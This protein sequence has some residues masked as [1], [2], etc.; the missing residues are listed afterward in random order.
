MTKLSNLTKVTTVG[1]DALFYIVDPARS[2]G[3]R[4]V[5]MDKDDVKTLVGGSGSNTIAPETDLKPINPLDIATYDGANNLTHISIEHV[6]GGWNGYKYWNAFTP[7]PDS[8][9]ENPSVQCSNN[10]KN[11]V[12]PTGLV[13][14]IK[15]QQDAIDEGY[16]FWSDT[17]IT[18]LP[19]NRML[20]LFRAGGNGEGVYKM[21]STDGVNWTNFTKIYSTAPGS[22]ARCLSPTIVILPNGNWRMFFINAIDGVAGNE[23]RYIDSSDEGANWSAVQICSTP[24]DVDRFWHMDII[25]V[26]GVY[27]G[28][29]NKEVQSQNGSEKYPG[30]LFHLKSDNADNWYWGK[31]NI[32]KS[33]TDVDANGYYR[34]SFI[35]KIGD[36]VTFDLWLNSISAGSNQ[37]TDSNW[38]VSY[39][40]N[41]DLNTKTV[42]NALDSSFTL[43]D[44]KKLSHNNK[45]LPI[46][47][48]TT[49]IT[50][51]TDLN[52][53]RDFVCSGYLFGTG[54]IEFIAGA[55]TTIV[56]PKGTSI[57]DVQFGR[58]DIV[59]RN[60]VFYIYIDD[61]DSSGSGGGD[62]GGGNTIPTLTG[63][64]IQTL[65]APFK[66]D[67]ATIDYYCKIIK[68]D[69]TGSTY[70]VFFDDNN[71]ISLSSKVSVTTTPNTET[72]GD[73]VGVDTWNATA[74]YDQI[75]GNELIE[76]QSGVAT[77]VQ[78]G[79]VN[80]ENNRPALKMNGIGSFEGSPDATINSNVAHSIYTLA[81]AAPTSSVGVM[82]SS[83]DTST[84]RLQIYIDKRTAKLI[85]LV[86]DLSDTTYS[87]TYLTT[88]AIDDQRRLVFTNNPQDNFKSYWNKVLQDTTTYGQ[89]Y[90]NDIMRIGAG[91]NNSTDFNGEFQVLATLNKEMTQT[92]INEL[93]DKFNEYF[94]F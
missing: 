60:D 38:R 47:N 26:N 31:G 86:K 30:G 51:T 53:R 20:L 35:A 50:I 19:D 15:N 14:P 57:L 28:I 59:R 62:N 11:W 82:F 36:E 85:H 75:T 32:L 58:F 54:Q 80:I 9:I 27:H 1:D 40:R 12:T 71:E 46:E 73:I 78:G 49:P 90:T 81:S 77:L 44:T 92:E 41:V 43:S 3:D 22:T 45:V 88:Q 68:S 72:L 56:Y 42:A 64:G 94:S 48:G 83:S 91:T 67:L 5:G 87:S 10:G 4:S 84:Y 55:N 63:L 25:E 52:V 66:S 16:G 24:T 76:T 33:G 39:R 6:E 61:L 93:D 89:T 18:L 37:I 21:E 65:Y 69:L 7:Y 34:S 79:I 13:N 2:S 23:L 17:D 29:F 74:I 70:Y 8:T